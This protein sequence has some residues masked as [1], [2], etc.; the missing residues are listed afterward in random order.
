MDARVEFPQTTLSAASRS[1]RLRRRWTGDRITSVFTLALAFPLA[2]TLYERGGGLLPLLA[3][4]L[5]VAVGWTLLFTRMR[6]KDMNWH[7]VPTAIIFSLLM[8]PEVPVWQALLALSFGVVVGEQVFGG[9]GYSFLHPAVAALAFLFFS[10]PATAA[11]QTDSQFVAAAVL[12]GAVLLLASGLISWRILLSVAVGFLGWMILKGGLEVPS[13][14]VLTS[15][16][17]LGA[18]YLVCEP[19]SAAATNPG[20]WT[21]GL[22]VGMLIVLLGEAGQGIGSTGAVVFAALLGSVFA[23]L[24]DHLVIRINVNRRKRRQWPT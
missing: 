5:L 6:G 15:G 21:Y 1:A 20:R 17:A 19:T 22:L 7:A 23:P 13:G 24:I 10:F 3:G 2:A 16:L 14:A 12:P 4:A 9:R 8:P 18:V 11:G